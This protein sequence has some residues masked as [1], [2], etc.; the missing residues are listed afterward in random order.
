MKVY[1]KLLQQNFSM[2]RSTLKHRH[3][4]PQQKITCGP[5]SVLSKKEENTLEKW[6]LNEE[7]S[8]NDSTLNIIYKNTE[9]CFNWGHCLSD[10]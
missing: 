5:A 10:I 3:K 2:S 9:L 4:N 6:M 7:K 8:S 1:Q